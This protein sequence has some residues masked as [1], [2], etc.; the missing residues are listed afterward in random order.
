MKRSCLRN[1]GSGVRIPRSAPQIASTLDDLQGG[2]CS[3]SAQLVTSCQPVPESTAPLAYAATIDLQTVGL[4]AGRRWWRSWTI[5]PKP[6]EFFSFGRTS[7]S[8]TLICSTCHH[9]SPCL[10]TRKRTSPSAKRRAA[11]SRRAQP[12][13]A[14]DGGTGGLTRA[15]ACRSPMGT[16][17][18]GRVGHAPLPPS[19]HLR[20]VRH[21]RQ[22]RGRVAARK[23]GV[24]QRLDPRLI[25]PLP[26]LEPTRPDL[27][28]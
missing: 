16:M 14:G 3:G 21:D 7:S 12:R 18:G 19:E 6:I 1:R 27:S 17:R 4:L 9:H 5:R 8:P 22:T 24:A 2:L 26:A 20:H 13:V 10:S 11:C 15:R 25:G 23:R 28:I